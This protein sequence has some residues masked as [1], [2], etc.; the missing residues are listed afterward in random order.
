[1]PAA[2]RLGGDGADLRHARREPLARRLAA[3][4]VGV[5]R[6]AFDYAR[7]YAKERR[8]F[9]VAIA[10]KQAIAFML[11]EMAIE[12]DATRLLTWE[13]AWKLDRGEDATREA[14][15]AKQLRRQHGAQDHRQRRAGARRPRLHPRPPGRAVAA[16]R[17]AASPPSKAW[18]SSD[19]ERDE[20][21]RTMIDFELSPRHRRRTQ[22]M[23]HMVA[24]QAMRPIAREYDEREHEKPWDFLNMMWQRLAAANPASARRRARTRRRKAAAPSS[25]QPAHVSSPIE[26]LSWGDAG[27]YLSIPNP[28]LGGAAVAAAGTPEQ[29]QRFLARFKGGKPKWGGDG[30]HRAGLR[31]GLAPPSSHG[32][33]ATATTGC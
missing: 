5:A 28:G 18:R 16:Q 30:D 8:A 23:I 26:E 2:T 20:G 7:D 11:A 33:C 25:A 22:Q 3:M 17:A 1:M 15:L 31:L 21:D 9:G 27:L 19:G 6:A 14:Y 32:A 12:I 4:A 10:Q 24:E 29:K 13:A